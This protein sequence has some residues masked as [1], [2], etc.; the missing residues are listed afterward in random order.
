MPVTLSSIKLVNNLHNSKVVGDIALTDDLKASSLAP[1]FLSDRFT[2]SQ[3]V[4]WLPVQVV[5][6][7]SNPGRA[8]AVALKGRNW[9][10]SHAAARQVGCCYQQLVTQSE[11]AAL[12]SQASAA[13]HSIQLQ[14]QA[15]WRHLYYL[16]AH[17]RQQLVPLSLP[18]FPGTHEQ[19]KHQKPLGSAMCIG[20]A[21]RGHR[22]SSLT[23]AVIMDKSNTCCCVSMAIAVS[24]LNCPQATTKL[25]AHCNQG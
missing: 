15:T 4:I 13:G 7:Q 1:C 24:L 6:E 19:P 9:S 8:S 3:K 20:P 21:Q 23:L 12:V 10:L 5:I 22:H 18:C 2:G 25:Q 16:T 14:V 17:T 11:L